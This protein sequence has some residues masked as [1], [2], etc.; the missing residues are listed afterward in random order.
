MQP[1]VALFADHVEFHVRE[2]ESAFAA[3]G[4]LCRRVRLADCG[5]D[6]SRPG[7]LA[8]PGFEEALPDLAVVR[9]VGAGAFES[10][11]L[12][13][14]LLHALQSCGVPVLNHARAIE[15]CVDKAATSFLLAHAGL[16]TPATFAVQT[17][18][19]ARAIFARE[20]GTLVLKPLFGA[21]GRGLK[22]LRS[23]DD[24]PEESEINGVFYLQRFVGPVS[25]P[26]VDMRLFVSRGRL[27]GAMLRRSQNWITNVKLG[28]APEAFA[29][30]PA[31][32]ALA[33]RAAAC[34]DADFA[35]VDMILDE[36]G[37]PQ[38]LEV[39]SMPGWRGL[40]SVTAVNLSGLIADDA[41]AALA[42]ARS[43]A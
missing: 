8:I 11:T 23:T 9:A 15:R 21:Q 33:L 43:A 19:A 4:V 37:A 32:V 1:R 30:E 27:L 38:I 14:G 31:L 3:R 35:G 39:N 12:R 28:G 29:P 34:V 42:Q 26:F 10:V 2:L 41:L 13:L 7:G 24:L 25:G 17:R 22:L 18:E 6:S 40:Q 5:F 16:P 36:T 20:G